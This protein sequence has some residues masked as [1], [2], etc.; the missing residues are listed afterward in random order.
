MKNLPIKSAGGVVVRET[1]KGYFVALLYKNNHWVLPKGKIEKGETERKAA[2][3][4]VSEELKIPVGELKITAKIGKSK[5][6]H[7]ET[8]EPKTV[9]FFLVETKHRKI[10]PIKKEG[11]KK[12]KWFSSENAV[13][14]ATFPETKEIIA[15][16]MKLLQ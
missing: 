11:F 13:R 5:Y 16:A 12:A 4:E 8:K 7:L 9:T 15:K 6:M 1:L 14:K 10:F 3:R 2:I